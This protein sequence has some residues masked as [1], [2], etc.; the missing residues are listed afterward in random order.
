[1]ALAPPT[2]VK[3]AV[4]QSLCPRCK[5]LVDADVVERDGRIVMIKRCPK[6]GVS[7]ALTCSDAEW[8]RWSR[9]FQRPG[10][11]PVH[12]A[13][14]SELGCPY[15]C[16]FCPE[17]EQHACVTLFEITQ[18]CNLECPACF[19][20]SPHGSHSS[21]EEIHAML[22]AV[23][24]AEGGPADVVML[25]GGE[26]TIHPQFEN[27]VERIAL[28]GRVKH[29]MVNSN[30]I[31]FAR[32]PELCDLLA[33]NRAKVYLQFDGLQSGSLEML[34]GSDLVETKLQ[35]LDRLGDAGVSVVLVATIAKGVNDHEIGTVVELGLEHPAVR[36]VS[37][38]PQFGEGRWVPF[39][40]MDRTTVTDVIAAIAQQTGGT[41]EAADFVPIPCCDPMCTAAT[42]AWVRD[43][44]VT[45]LPRIVDVEHYLDY[46][47]D[48]ASPAVNPTFENDFA[49]MRA[50]LE[51]LYSKSN[52][53]GS[54]GQMHAFTCACGPLV[55]LG[56]ADLSEQLFSITIEAFMDRH[57]FDVSRARKCCIQEALPDGRIV[58]FCV[59]NT[60]HRFAPGK[61]ALPPVE[62]EAGRA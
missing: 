10:R 61:R 50:T 52:P 5:R 22:D 15:D 20:A 16:G 46:I 9:R 53:A 6:H 47:Q 36:A 31:R 49:E 24:L 19:A 54:E 41:F 48:S 11:P 37:F 29:L 59:Y 8:Y 40:P 39:D 27:I 55:E 32:Q 4:T 14:E 51:A 56:S 3:L 25:S 34:R 28:S 43:G 13:T 42:Y 12:R 23:N 35:A 44:R 58:P 1:M 17:H 2:E 45:P 57:N 7:E 30:G 62:A 33:A 26:P 18:A 60:L 38:Q 21:L